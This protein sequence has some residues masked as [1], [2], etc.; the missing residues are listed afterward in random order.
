[1]FRLVCGMD[2]VHALMVVNRREVPT[3]IYT[4][5]YRSTRR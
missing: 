3:L 2:A 5:W 4:L 1:V